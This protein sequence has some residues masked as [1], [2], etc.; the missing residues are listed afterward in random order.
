MDCGPGTAGQVALHVAPRELSGVAISHFHPDHYFDVVA[1]YYV[2][3]FNSKPAARVP[4]WV[5]PGGGAFLKRFGGLVADKEALLQDLFEVREYPVLTPVS[6]G[7]LEF[8][9]HPVKHYIPSYAMRVRAASGEVLTFSSDVAPCPELPVAARDADL[10]L[11]ES[12]LLNA[13]QDDPHVDK[14]GHSSAFEA[15]QAAA[16]AQAKRLLLTHYRSS[17]EEDA[18]HLASARETFRGPVELAKPG[19]TYTVV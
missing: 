18:H 14:R 15:G 7:A 4:L 17:P 8:T 19:N 6:I 10:F 2:L 1:L 16:A 12:A 11:C 3:K 9:F 13:S 5:P